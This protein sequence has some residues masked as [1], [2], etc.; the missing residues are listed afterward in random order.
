MPLEL[1][2]RGKVWWFKGRIEGLPNSRYYRQSTQQTTKA[3]ASAILIDFQKRELVRHHSGEEKSLTFA[4]AVDLYDANQEMAR[5]L[6]LVLDELGR[7]PLSKISPKLVRDLGPKLY[8]SGSTDSWRR[9]V[10]TPV[11]AVINNAHALGLAALIRIDS[12]S[13]IELQRQDT[14]RGKQSRKEKT[15]GSWPWI[16]Q[17]RG[18]A[19][20]HLGALALFMFMTGARIGQ[21]TA[22]RRAD[23]DLDN[24][25]I[26][27]P[28]AKG[29]APQWVA[30]DEQ[31]ARELSE[32][33]PRTTRLRDG[34]RQVSDRLFGYR[35]KDSLYR[36]WRSICR[37]A[38]IEE[39]M[40]HA[41]G[42]H[43]FGTEM[44]VRQGIDP[45]TVARAG[46]WADTQMLIKTYA[47]SEDHEDRVLA[48]FR[49]GRVQA[50]KSLP[51]NSMNSKVKSRDE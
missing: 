41:A 5:D 45:V 8:P 26:W 42:R 30:L 19:T 18:A 28:G 22:I 47:H 49:T 3:G 25:R 38:G 32:L 14:R 7:L 1:Y 50:E 44:V 4:E 48:A 35:R 20:P 33:G 39:I 15:A 9:H 23:L 36:K 51:S 34:R 46:R 2:E 43:G 12:Y 27:M 21:S 13:K 10:V 17:F 29:A 11:R 37:A 6:L 24:S 16:L 40:P 31:L